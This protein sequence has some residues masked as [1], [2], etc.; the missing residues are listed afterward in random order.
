M[1]KTPPAPVAAPSTVAR[2]WDSALTL[3]ARRSHSSSGLAQVPQISDAGLA[4]MATMPENRSD[5]SY[6]FSIATLTRSSGKTLSTSLAPGK[7]I[8]LT[9]RITRSVA[10]TS[11]LRSPGPARPRSPSTSPGFRDWDCS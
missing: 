9:T 3:K 11:R 5:A 2:A 10:S 6:A 1:V 8:L 7:V 4:L